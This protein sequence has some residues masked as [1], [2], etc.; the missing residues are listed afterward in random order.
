M[1]LESLIGESLASGANSPVAVPIT[2]T[3]AAR[4]ENVDLARP[5]SKTD[6]FR[7]FDF[8]K[9]YKMLVIP[10]QTGV[11]P[12]R[13]A[14]FAKIF[15]TP[16]ETP[17]VVHP[18]I[19]DFP[20]VKIIRSSGRPSGLKDAL[21]FGPPLP[22]D[23]WHTDGSSRQNETFRTI[24]ILQAIDIPDHGRDTLFADMEAAFENLSDELK[25]FLSGLTAQHMDDPLYL[26][27]QGKSPMKPAIH[28]VVMTDPMTGGRALYVNRMFTRSIVELRP[29]ESEY[30]LRFL[31]SQPHR[32]EYQA[33]VAWTPGT[34]VIWEN[35][36]TQHYLVQDMPYKRVM[37]RVMTTHK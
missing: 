16:D 14:E 21:D 5:L 33:R 34:I 4:L 11:D 1:T 18:S 27:S 23:S 36:R 26:L 10:D 2:P 28:P 29:D 17:H 24:S 32:P 12:K 7:I 19:P 15:G 6:Q 3:F 31:F 8:L 9:K 13:L 25:T 30:L 35:A 37:H 22:W 20:E